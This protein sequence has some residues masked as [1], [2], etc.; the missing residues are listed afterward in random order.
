MRFADS[1]LEGGRTYLDDWD[2]NKQPGDMELRRMTASKDEVDIQKQTNRPEQHEMNMGHEANASLR[3]WLARPPVVEAWI[4]GSSATLCSLMEE[5]PWLSSMMPVV[6]ARLLFSQFS[7]SLMRLLLPWIAPSM[8]CSFPGFPVP[9][10]ASGRACLSRSRRF[11]SPLEQ[12]LPVP[13]VPAQKDKAGRAGRQAIR[14]RAS[15][16]QLHLVD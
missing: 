7:V 9:G 6:V 14:L 3:A 4:Q 11:S 1:A 12:I 15:T 2:R 5:T 16:R 8:G 10:R 13:V